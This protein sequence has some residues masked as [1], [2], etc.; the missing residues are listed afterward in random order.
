MEGGTI[1]VWLYDFVRATLTPLTTGKGSSQAPRWT[2]DG[3]R[4]VYRATRT[5]YAEPVVE[6]RGRCDG[7]R[8]CDDRRGRADAKLV[9]E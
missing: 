2:P 8:A 6:D 5:G 9:F 1:G 3:T 7:R 4:I